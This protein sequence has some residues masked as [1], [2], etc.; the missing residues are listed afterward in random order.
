MHPEE[1]KTKL[2]DEMFR[3]YLRVHDR[4]AV[5]YHG[6]WPASDDPAPEP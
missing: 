5:L 6:G 1:E 2:Y 4:L 3:T